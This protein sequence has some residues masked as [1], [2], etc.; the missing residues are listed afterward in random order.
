MD[1]QMSRLLASLF[2]EKQVKVFLPRE[3][4]VD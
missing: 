3:V 2:L 1:K 4:E